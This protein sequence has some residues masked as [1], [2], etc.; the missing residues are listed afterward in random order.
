MMKGGETMNKMW[1]MVVLA[2]VAGVFIGYFVE[3]SRAIA[4]MESYK[5]TVDK[6]MEQAKMENDTMMNDEKTSDDAMMMK[7][8]V[9]P[10]GDTMMMKTSVT[11]ADVMKK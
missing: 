4:N 1:F 2:L 3:R 8:K 10:T 11:P 7:D 6:Q 9:T 5:M